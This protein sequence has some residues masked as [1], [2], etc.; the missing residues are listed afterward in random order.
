MIRSVV[1]LILHLLIQLIATPPTM[2]SEMGRQD[3]DIKDGVGNKFSNYRSR[4]SSMLLMFSLSII[5][6]VMFDSVPLE[7][8]EWLIFAICV[9]GAV[10]SL[11]AYY[12]L[13]R[14]YTFEIGIRKE[15]QL[16]TN[17]PYKY[18]A[19]PGYC[20]QLLLCGGATLF[21]FVT[22]V[23]SYVIAIYLVYR[24]YHRIAAEERMLR[25]HF[26]DDYRKFL[27]TRWRIIPYVI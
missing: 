21:W 16:V 5:H 17:G 24:F 13:G 2:G 19:H 27:S 10:T 9:I 15:H 8:H 25:K 20:G 14:Y 6:T 26:G 4:V 18:L 1:T 22:P 7:I 3:G 23:I 12:V 11:S